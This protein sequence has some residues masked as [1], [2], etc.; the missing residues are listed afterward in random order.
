M[1]R[2][3]LQSLL[4]KR[5]PTLE[6]RAICTVLRHYFCDPDF[7]LPPKPEPTKS[8][9][10]IVALDPCDCVMPEAEETDVTEELMEEQV[11]SP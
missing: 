1:F 8:L 11:N 6:Y 4:T 7:G 3:A 9:R 10:E 2:Q 5:L